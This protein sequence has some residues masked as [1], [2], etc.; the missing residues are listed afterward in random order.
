MAFALKFIGRVDQ[1]N[2][3][4]G[5]AVSWLMPLMA[6]SVF[7]IA[8]LRYAFN[9]GWVWSQEL[10]LY[11]HGALFM[12]GMAYALLKGAHVRIDI[13]YR[14]VSL[15][16]RALIDI[17]GSVLLLFPFCLLFLVHAVPY[18]WSSW[19]NW[20]GSPQAGGLPLVY[21]LKTL[22]V[23][24]PLMLFMQGLSLCAKSFLILCGKEIIRASSRK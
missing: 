6:I 20:E 16:R 15:R 4:L 13:F 10:T 11:M 18:V 22:M 3:I 12:L 21:L 8:F 2:A 14:N 17:A 5:Q 1:V 24:M 9:L 23:L 19:Q 7:L